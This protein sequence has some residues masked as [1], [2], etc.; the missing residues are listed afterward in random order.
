MARGPFRTQRGHL[1]I[2]CDEVKPGDKVCL[3]DG[4][5]LPFLLRETGRINDRQMDPDYTVPWHVF[6]GGEV[7]VLGMVDGEG[8][9]VAR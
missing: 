6:V 5:A 9:A 4:G 3:L 7:Y 1:G 8:V 2:N